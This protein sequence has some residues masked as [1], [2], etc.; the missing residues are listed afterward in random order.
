MLMKQVILLTLILGSM[1]VSGRD[2]PVEGHQWADWVHCNDG[3]VSMI[4]PNTAYTLAYKG[5]LAAYVI[6]NCDSTASFNN[7]Q[8]CLM[9]K[10]LR[11]VDGF[12]VQ[13]DC[14]IAH[15]YPNPGGCRLSC[16]D[17]VCVCTNK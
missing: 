5:I 4:P 8:Y 1:M 16:H 6:N 13:A 3:F 14:L 2:M 7:D 10:G 17:N 12:R 15:S 11:S 9:E